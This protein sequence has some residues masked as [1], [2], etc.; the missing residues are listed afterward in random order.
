MQQRR[1]PNTDLDVSVVCLGTMTFGTPVD[2]Q[3]VNGIIDWCLDNG[4]N[5]IDT[6]D[7][8]EGYTRFLGSP[9]GKSEAYIGNALKGRRDRAVITTKVGNPVGDD[10][11]SGTG[12]GRDHILHQIDA[13]LGR[14][15]TDYVD[16]YEMHR[17]DPDTPLAE[18]IATM[19]G[20]IEAGKVRHWGF[21]NFE[22]DDIHR[23]IA[24]CDDNDWPR[25]VIAQPQLSW[26]VRDSEEA[27]IPAC[28]QYDI[29]V[30]PYRTLQS[31]LLD[32]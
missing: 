5:F 17:D 1:I 7:M 30:T 32:R 3:G 8:Y 16:I 26:L 23:M 29:A 9:G 21:S 4:L 19:A 25:P 20:L 10:S 11:Y 24:L 28:V 31:G 12:L 18:S 6:A 22:P 14:L 27:Y 15:R 13:S 2:Q